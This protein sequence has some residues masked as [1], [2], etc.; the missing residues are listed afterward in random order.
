MAF[1]IV[2]LA[3]VVWGVFVD[4][5]AIL[6]ALGF[7]AHELSNPWVR[8][9]LRVIRG[10]CVLI[11]VLL[12][13]SRLALS[14]P[15]AVEW[16][17]SRLNSM[18][19]ATAQT[20]LF[21]LAVTVLI[22][23]TAVLQLLLYMA[24]YTA[25]AAD[26]FGRPLSA[27]FWLRNPTIDLGMDGWLGLAGSGWLPFSDYVFAAGLAVHPDLFIT[28]RV[29]NLIISSLAVVSAYLLGRELFGRA[30]GLA[31]AFLFT[32]QPWH[33]WLGMSGMS[34][35]L[36]SLVLIPLFGLFFFRWLRTDQ[37]TAVVAA[38]ACLAVANGFRYEN[39][40]FAA[41]FS[42]VVVLIVAGRWRQHTLNRR[43]LLSAAAAVLLVNAFPVAWMAAS[44]AAF[45]DWLPAMH[46]INAFM[47]AGI[48]SQTSRVETQ[49]GIPLMAVGSFPFELALSIAGIAL[50]AD[51]R[52]RPF[53]TYIAL[54][55]A[56]A[57]VFTA[58][59][60]GQLAAW[61][62]IA[63]YLFG[64]IVLALP[65]AGLLIV[66]LLTAGEPWRRERLVAGCVILVTVAAFDVSRAANYP[67]G[68]PRDAVD[69]GWMIRGL[70]RAGTVRSDGRILIE[71][72]RDFSDLSIVVL[73]N[74]PERFV[75]LNE[76]AYRRMAL[77]GLLA[78]SPA[79]MP[80]VADEGVRGTVCENDFGVPA[81]RDSVRQGDFDLVI[82][83]TP[84]R[85][86]SFAR[87]FGARSWKIGRYH[88]F[89]LKAAPE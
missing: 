21:P 25:F 9:D 19:A 72:T 46:G 77:S 28:P 48:S 76:L 1:V 65:F 16:L 36:P 55:V 17:A 57:L 24:G 14:R 67:S 68:F 37:P 6:R 32:F 4:W 66:R 23:A 81:C 54:I 82:L 83:S 75:V 7:P 22:L 42:V 51:S 74:R 80:A 34:S 71:R 59:F 29:V 84:E 10:T 70:Q 20:M 41:V 33:V 30:V 31:T 79:L 61:L 52:S 39:W 63:R 88:V 53:R 58:T 5:I 3:L 35:D 87:T 85:V 43:F 26:D 45:G 86:S 15:R 56:T 38:G 78:N 12:V 49:M 13:V 44:Y 40:L 62:S 73:A 27:A 18:R 89:H 8:G 64:F 2:G 69:T 60:G 47:V 11:G 50:F